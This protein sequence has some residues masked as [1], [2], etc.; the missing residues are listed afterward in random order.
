MQLTTHI[1]RQAL[2]HALSVSAADHFNGKPFSAAVSDAEGNLLG[3]LR[4]EVAPAMTIE[5]AQRKAYTSARMRVTTK[6]LLERLKKENL[7]IHYF[8]DARFTAIPGGIP[9]FDADDVCIGA[10][11]M[12]GLSADGGNHN[13]AEMVAR[14][15]MNEL[16]KN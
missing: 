13:A 15:I 6:A 10:V 12:A 9:L 2:D 11:G 4:K 14:F 1:V 3:F 5:L 16:S 7:E 8:A